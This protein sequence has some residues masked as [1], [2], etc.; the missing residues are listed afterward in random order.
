MIEDERT[1][2]ETLGGTRAVGEQIS[3]AMNSEIGKRVRREAEYF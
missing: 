2:Y 1:T 3:R